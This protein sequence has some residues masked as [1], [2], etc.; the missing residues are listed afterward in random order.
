MRE[1][2]ALT[3]DD[4][5]GATVTAH[6]FGWVAVAPLIAYGLAALVHLAARA[7]GARGS[8]L[9]ARAALFWSALAGAPVALG[10]ALVGV[11][12]EAAA[13]G[14]A[15]LARRAAADRAS[16]SGLWLFAASLAETE[17]FAATAG[18][19][20][21]GRG[22]RRIGGLLALAAGGTAGRRAGRDVGSAGHR[23]LGAAAAAAQQVLAAALPAGAAASR[24]RCSS[25]ASAWCS[26]MRRCG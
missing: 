26:A 9:A 17:G 6:L 21:G 7:F 10:V 19:G 24:R 23:Q 15:R 1:A 18:R 22:L 5:V 16:A 2:R 14:R 11:A 20:G 13:T 3:V 8:F 4:P 12:A 25:P